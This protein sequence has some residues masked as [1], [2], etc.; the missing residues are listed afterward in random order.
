MKS[1][2]ETPSK[3]NSRLNNGYTSWHKSFLNL[4][5]NV[6]KIR[7]ENVSRFGVSEHQKN[8]KN[9]NLELARLHVARKYVLQNKN[10]AEK[11]NY[12]Y[13]IYLHSKYTI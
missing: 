1:S 5:R 12:N 13:R 7:L 4:W 10:K 6:G 2:L 9:K 11:L 8:E 3:K